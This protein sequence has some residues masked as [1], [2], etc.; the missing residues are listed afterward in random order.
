MADGL[1]PAATRGRTVID[2]RVYE[3]TARAA[4][5][6]APDVVEHRGAGALVGRSLPRVEVRRSDDHVRVR[7]E[8]A[9]AWPTPLDAA[10]AAVRTTVADTLARV[11][12][13]TVDAVDVTVTHLEPQDRRHR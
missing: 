13:S 8:V 10:T 3:R 4:T 2:D 6:A 7:L 12:G 11:T 9:L 1:A 5:L